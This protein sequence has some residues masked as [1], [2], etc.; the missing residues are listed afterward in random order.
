VATTKHAG[1]QTLSYLFEVDNG[2]SASGVWLKGIAAPDKAAVTIVLSDQGRRAAAPDIS[3]RLNR[4]EQVMALDLVFFGNAKKDIPSAS[5]AQILASEG[6]RAL[7]IQAAQLIEIARWIR[8]R[9]GA[10]KV[11]LEARG[12]RTQTIGL[13][14]AALQPDLFSEATVHDGMPSLGFL[15]EAPVT[16]GDA[17]ELFCLDL[18]R[19]FDL[20]R[21]AAIAAPTR[22]KLETVVKKPQ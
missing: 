12:I 4:D 17:P 11:R 14:A 19:D 6:E 7:G 8:E 9:A 22:V 2:L 21:L 13:V 5:Y 18:Y 1:V 15:L 20:D 16:F 10:Q 3:E